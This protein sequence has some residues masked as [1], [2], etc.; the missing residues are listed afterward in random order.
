MSLPSRPL[1]HNVLDL[2][3]FDAEL[4]G[5]RACK[6]CNAR[7]VAWRYFIAWTVRH[8]RALGVIAV[9]ANKG[10]TGGGAA[11]KQAV[12]AFAT[13][14]YGLAISVV[15]RPPT[16]SASYPAPKVLLSDKGY[17][18]EA[19]RDDVE[20]RPRTMVIPARKTTRARNLSLAT[21][22]PCETSSN[23]A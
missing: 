11:I 18:T 22:M 16:V 21:S 2:L 19:N 6:C 3:H 5:V 13:D 14:K 7:I 20:A 8:I 23:G 15:E 1:D 12:V 10:P 17:D 4:F 9:T